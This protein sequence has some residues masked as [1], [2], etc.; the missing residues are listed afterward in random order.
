MLGMGLAGLTSGKLHAKPRAKR[1]PPS[2]EEYFKHKI[3]ADEIAHIREQVAKSGGS[4]HDALM[5]RVGWPPIAFDGKLSFSH[6]DALLLGG[7]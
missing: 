1:S 5:D 4:L 2:L 7:K 6:Q 3:P